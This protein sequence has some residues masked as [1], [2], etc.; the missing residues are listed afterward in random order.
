MLLAMIPHA[1]ETSTVSFPD[2]SWSLGQHQTCELPAGYNAGVKWHVRALD[3]WLLGVSVL[4]CLAFWHW[5][6][7]VYIPANAAEVH[8]RKLPVGNNSDLYPRWL[9]ARELLLHGRDP[10]SAE[11]TR[12]IQMGFYGRPLDPNKETDPRDKEAFAYPMWVVFLL[13]PTVTLPF[14]VVV[15]I[16]R[17]IL[18]SCIALSVPVWMYTMGF[19]LRPAII[20]SGVLLALSSF[21]SLVEYYQ[22]NL[23]AILVFLVAAATACVVRNWLVLAG[24]LLALATMKPDTCVLLIAWFL[25]W[26]FSNW[27]ER[28]RLVWSFAATT[29]LLVTM[30]EATLPHWIP[31]FV[32]AVRDYSTY[33]TAPNILQLLFPSFLGILFSFLLLAF[34]FVLWFQ[35]RTADATTLRFRWLLAWTC[36]V[37]LAVIPKHAAYNQ[38]LLIPPFLMLLSQFRDF[39]RSGVIPRAFASTPFVCLLLQWLAAAILSFS[40]MFGKRTLSPFAAELPDHIFLAIVPL[41]LLAM[42]AMTFL[43]ARHQPTRAPIAV[44]LLLFSGH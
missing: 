11:I 34:L 40:M 38:L 12:E 14:K 22:Q 1:R 24:F 31:R 27:R 42:A 39:Q 26:A 5:T 10:Y 4:F 16:F 18:I 43:P 21:P 25:L 8:A 29:V 30:S 37:T 20:L 28:Q 2:G 15:E 32:V 19:R 33:A 17:W 41:T 23:V 7:Y 3:L 35:W 44:E 36:I 6:K 13:A 9:G